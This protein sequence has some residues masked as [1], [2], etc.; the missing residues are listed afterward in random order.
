MGLCA[1]CCFDQS[2]LCSPSRYHPVSSIFNIFFRVPLDGRE[3]VCL[4]DSQQKG[5]SDDFCVL[6]SGI[7]PTSRRYGMNICRQCFRERAAQIGFE[8]VRFR[9]RRR[10][11]P[12]DDTAPVIHFG[13]YT[14]ARNP[15]MK[16]RANM[17]FPVFVLQH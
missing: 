5:R 4:Y 1:F 15:Q 16:W 17:L 6:A 13:T 14:V 11:F 9:P 12:L 10:R 7:C 8:K 2:S 3:V